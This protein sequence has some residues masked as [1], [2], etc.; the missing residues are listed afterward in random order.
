VIH[1]TLD[2][3]DI[4]MALVERGRN[5]PGVLDP[6]EDPHVGIRARQ[7]RE[8]PWQ[9][10]G[11]HGQARGDPQRTGHPTLR[12][13]DRPTRRLAFGQQPMGPLH[14]RRARWRE[15]DTSPAAIEELCPELPFEGSDL[16][17]DSRLGQ[18]QLVRGAREVALPRHRNKYLQPTQVHAGLISSVLLIEV[19]QIRHVEHPL[20]CHSL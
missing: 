6:D 13:G 20:E 15:D 17:A 10:V 2:E 4:G 16:L 9:K 3:P 5:M 7:L 14:E 11:R 1:F 12:G 8:G 19:S 18:M